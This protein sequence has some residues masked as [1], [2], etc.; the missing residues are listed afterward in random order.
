[1]GKTWKTDSQRVRGPQ[2]AEAL[3]VLFA[4][5]LCGASSSAADSDC[6]KRV[7]VLYSFRYGLSGNA[8]VDTNSVVGRRIRS[9][10]EEGTR[11]PIAFYSERMDVSILSD[12]HYFEQLRDVYRERYASERIDLII[13][14]NYRALSF[15]IEH[16]E[17]LWP[18]TP[19]VF[20]GVEV[21]RR[22][23]LE[24]LRPN[25]TG[26][27][28]A[29]GLGNTLDTILEIHPDTRQIT[30]IAGTSETDQFIEGIAR[31]AFREHTDRIEFTYLN[32][33][34]FDAILKKVSDLPP[35][36]VVLFLTLLQDDRGKPVPINALPLISSKSNVPLYGM[37]DA[38]VGYGIFGGRLAS[39]ENKGSAV[40]KLGLR[41][42]EGVRPEDIP[43]D[44]QMH[45]EINLYD[46][47]QLQRWGISEDRLPS[48]S[49]VRFK[50]EPVW[51]RY[52]WQIIGGIGLCVLEGV[53][54]FSLALNWV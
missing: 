53:T 16:G 42:L 8:V 35:E 26:I 20:C 46:W 12:D 28:Q 27:I 17:E 39:Y 49:I 36:S 37:F 21:N 10:F 50:E 33:L 4:W 9:T 43:I 30:V 54:I 34:A 25:I 5:L 11:D 14:V 2:I 13:A 24:Q 52:R 51:D 47:R 44:V 38:Y 48:G 31:Q 29:A 1:M 23:Q 6:T 32:D 22:K 19:I 3:L 15:L 40:A 45:P 18:T 41:I 7:L